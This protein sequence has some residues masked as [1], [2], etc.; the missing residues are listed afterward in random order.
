[1]LTGTVLD[2]Q[3]QPLGLAIISLEGQPGEGHDYRGGRFRAA[4][5]PRHAARRYPHAGGAPP[6]LQPL[7]Q[8]V[9]RPL[10]P[11]LPCASR[12]KPTPRRPWAA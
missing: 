7:R 11:G 6:G 9:R 3:G 12:C 2:A 4:P 10:A 5:T 8:V 1:M